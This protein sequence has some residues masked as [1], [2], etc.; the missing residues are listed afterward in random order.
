MA[1]QGVFIPVSQP[2]GEI[3]FVVT[4][5]HDLGEQ[6][7]RHSSTVYTHVANHAHAR[8]RRSLVKEDGATSMARASA[9]TRGKANQ[10][11][12]GGHRSKQQSPDN[13]IEEKDKE[14]VRRHSL[15]VNRSPPDTFDEPLLSGIDPFLQ[16]PVAMSAREKSYFNYCM[17]SARKGR[18]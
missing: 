11:H 15:P 3:T 10:E 1:G 12:A 7:L 2:P 6:A 18:H 8:R 13:S 9:S 5:Q 14:V 4:T 16:L 17:Y